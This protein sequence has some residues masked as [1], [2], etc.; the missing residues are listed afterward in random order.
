MTY[1]VFADRSL[2]WSAPIFALP[3][4]GRQKY[5]V[6]E[7]YG[8]LVSDVS[9]TNP[10]TTLILDYSGTGP[11]G[12][13]SGELDFSDFDTTKLATL[14]LIQGGSTSQLQIVIKGYTHYDFTGGDGVNLFT[15]GAGNDSFTGGSRDDILAGRGGAD[16]LMGLG[17]D[18]E[19]Y[20]GNGSDMI[21]GGDDDDYIDGGNGADFMYGEDGDDVIVLRGISEIIDGGAGI[22]EL[23]V[24]LG[25]TTTAGNITWDMMQPG[26]HNGFE[27]ISGILTGFSDSVYAQHQYANLDASGGFYNFGFFDYRGTFDGRDVAQLDFDGIGVSNSSKINFSDGT[28]ETFYISNFH[29]VTVHGSAFGDTINGTEGDDIL[30]GED[31]DDIITGRDGDDH[32]EGGSGNDTFLGVTVGDSVIGGDDTDKAEIDLSTATEGFDYNA[33]ISQGDI[34]VEQIWGVLTDHDD[35][36]YINRPVGNLD[37]GDGFDV[38]GANFA[39]WDTST[40]VHLENLDDP[41]AYQNFDFAS[42]SSDAFILS[43][44]ERFNL[45][46]TLGDD[47]FYGLGNDDTAYG[48]DG[49]DQLFGMGGDDR[50]YTGDGSD[51]L[52]GGDGADPLNFQGQNAVGKGGTGADTFIFSGYAN[53][54]TDWVTILDF[55][56]AEDSIVFTGF[57]HDGS[58]VQLIVDGEVTW[59]SQNNGRRNG[60]DK[61]MRLEAETDGG[62]TFLTI[63]YG[64]QL[65]ERILDG[66]QIEFENVTAY[67]L[68]AAD[69]VVF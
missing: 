29:S 26:G 63:N 40:S 2:W 67:E 50:L 65:K 12:E 4:E 52:D 47:V 51:D 33:F 1:S 14:E 57:Q 37:G 38:L 49:N 22:D 68:S 61:M 32:M 44:F 3:T 42:G 25:G 16:V 30:K 64:F 66:T 6:T 27:R 24:Q 17:G 43:N 11:S 62:S 7:D 10:S 20:G 58:D 36:V 15:G 9:T 18:D 13:T 31:G 46:L 28:S 5:S 54:D 69:M 56:E 34:Q 39:I 59:L 35:D 41:T 45:S 55:D 53:G 21:Y 19:L 8:F 60:T 48:N 23:H